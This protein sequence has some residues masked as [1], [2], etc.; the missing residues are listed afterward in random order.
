MQKHEA[1]FKEVELL[2]QRTSSVVDKKNKDQKEYVEI[3]LEKVRKSMKEEV[4]Y[5]RLFMKDVDK[6]TT[7]KI[8]ELENTVMTVKD[9]MFKTKHSLED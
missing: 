3:E 4:N 9:I 5:M 7:D 6:K 8:G 2:L 1:R